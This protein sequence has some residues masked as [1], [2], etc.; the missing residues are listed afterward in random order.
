MSVIYTDGSHRTTIGWAWCSGNRHGYGCSTQMFSLGNTAK[1]GQSAYIAEL[2]SV[3][4]GIKGSV[5]EDLLIVND[6]PSVVAHVNDRELYKT[7]KGKQ[8]RT[9]QVD[10]L[11]VL[12][13]ICKDRNV[14]ATFP[15]DKNKGRHGWCHRSSRKFSKVD[16][17]LLG[18]EQWWN[19][20]K[21][22]LVPPTPAPEHDPHWSCTLVKGAPPPLVD[23]IKQ[24]A[25]NRWLLSRVGKPESPPPE[26]PEEISILDVDGVPY[27]STIYVG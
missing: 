17:S 21:K 2:F 6:C 22:T 20:N 27:V 18:F 23:E 4:E 16:K 24:S 26:S 3:I 15:F 14:K 8:A 19:A 1:V 5:D 9:A 11:E 13:L 25:A 12:N 7:F 10:L